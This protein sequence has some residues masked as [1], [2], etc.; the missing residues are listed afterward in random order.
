MKIQ[1]YFVKDF[2]TQ[3][4]DEIFSRTMADI[5]NLIKEAEEQKEDVYD[6]PYLAFTQYTELLR[7]L[8]DILVND[9]YIENQKLIFNHF[10]DFQE[11][12]VP[13]IKLLVAF[14]NKQ[15]DAGNLYLVGKYEIDFFEMFT[16]M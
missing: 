4:L 3:K 8:K 15:F 9:T 16:E 11:A 1:K 13:K 10:E 14:L 2:E 12:I 6:T 7:S 5:E